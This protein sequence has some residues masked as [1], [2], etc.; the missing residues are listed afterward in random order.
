METTHL[1]ETTDYFDKLRELQAL[2]ANELAPESHAF[3]EEFKQYTEEDLTVFADQ[4]KSIEQ[5]VRALLNHLRKK[6]NRTY[7]CKSVS[8]ARSV[9]RQFD[10]HH[11]V[12]LW[13]NRVKMIIEF[14]KAFDSMHTQLGEDNEG[15]WWQCFLCV[16]ICLFVFFS[17]AVFGV[18]VSYIMAAPAAI[19][20]SIALGVAVQVVLAAI[21]LQVGALALV[22]ARFVCGEINYCK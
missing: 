20:I 8:N 2:E 9:L 18:T 1:E 16:G 6:A 7:F 10:I 22:V 13:T 5:A 11:H 17:V 15:V 12:N 19:I 21:S 4:A 14:V 3:W